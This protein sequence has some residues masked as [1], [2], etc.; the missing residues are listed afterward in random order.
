VENVLDKHPAIRESAVFAVPERILGEKIVACVV[1]EPGAT[2]EADELRT[3]C[4]KSLPLVRTP[5][6]IRVSDGLPKTESGKID[7]QRVK[8]HFEE[9]AVAK[10]YI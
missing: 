2:V 5:R 9:L 3:Y 1:L 8:T 10:V 7:R 4:L 6:E